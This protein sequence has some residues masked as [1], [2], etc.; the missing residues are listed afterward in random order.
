M[1]PL[2]LSNS[3]PCFLDRMSKCHIDI[4]HTYDICHTSPAISFL[5]FSTRQNRLVL[6]VASGLSLCRP[7]NSGFKE[8][9]AGLER[10]AVLGIIQCDLY[11]V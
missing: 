11:S 5:V 9:K 1:G 6:T 4:C 10:I 7:Q 2:L 8:N 3:I